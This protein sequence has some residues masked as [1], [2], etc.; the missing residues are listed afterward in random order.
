MQ[1]EEKIILERRER[2]SEKSMLWDR[3][4]LAQKFSAS[5]LGKFG[6]ELSFIRKEKDHSIAVLTCNSGIAIITE[7]GEIDTSPDITLRD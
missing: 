6:Y 4:S 3:L 5:S 7:D 2:S 1:A